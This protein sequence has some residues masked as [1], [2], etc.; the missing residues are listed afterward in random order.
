MAM[1]DRLAARDMLRVSAWAM[2][3]ASALPAS[4]LRQRALREARSIGR[5]AL[6]LA[7]GQRGK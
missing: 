7:Q 1:T 3:W 5:I 6:G 4:P 2:V